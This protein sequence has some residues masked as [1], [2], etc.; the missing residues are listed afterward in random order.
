M[1]DDGITLSPPDP[2]RPTPSRLYKYR[3]F[4]ESAESKERLRSIVVDH[5]LYF[6]TRANFNDPFDCLMP[7]FKDV[8]DASMKKYIRSRLRELGI[9]ANRNQAR[10]MSQ[11]IDLNRL[12]EDVQKPANEIEILC[13]TEDPLNMLMWGHYAGAHTGLCLE[14]SVSHAEPFFGRA[15]PV[16]YSAKRGS[17]DPDK[18]PG[19]NAAATILR[20]SIDWMYEHEWRI[21]ELYAG[22]AN[23]TFPSD[24]LTGLIL[25]YRME[26]K[27]RDQ[28]LELVAEGAHGLRIYEALP[29]EREYK[30]RLNSLGGNMKNT[31]RPG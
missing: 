5:Q 11:R 22:P 21:V 19:E 7:S 14:F 16:V 27:A 18:E 13:L 2:K 29:S 20:K 4:D 31:K 8:F 30:M 24:R 15:Q 6:S 10:G 26:E 9:A 17:F 1:V 23:Y 28:V 25:G 3:G 12:H